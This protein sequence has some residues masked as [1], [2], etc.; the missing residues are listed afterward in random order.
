MSLQY[1]NKELDFEDAKSGLRSY[2][3]YLRPLPE[4]S[5]EPTGY[6]KSGLSN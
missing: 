5:L 3:N 2:Y 4:N 1:W 6:T